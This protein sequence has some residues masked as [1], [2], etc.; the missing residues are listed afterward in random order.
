LTAAIF[1][2]TQLPQQRREDAGMTSFNILGALEI[3]CHGM[4]PLPSAP[5][6]RSLLALLL[7]RAGQLVPV[8]AI[9]DE[10]W[11]EA[12]PRS[13]VTTTQTYI[14]QLRKKLDETGANHGVT[15]LETAP[16]GYLLRLGDDDLDAVRF[17]RLSTMGTTL[18][19][20]GDTEG[21]GRV[22]R[23]ALALWRGPALTNVVLGP[24]LSAHVAHLD[25]LRIQALASRIEADMAQGRHRELVA[26]L[27]SLVCAYPLNEWFHGQLI[28]ALRRSGRRSDALVAYHH[29]RGLLQRELGLDPSAYLQR[30]HHAVLTADAPVREMAAHVPA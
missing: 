17:Y 20:R 19:E 8:D 3:E 14:C 26:E 7:V 9:I 4:V 12:P 18:A 29:V 2:F 27:R 15:M 24:L 30:L 13:A 10:L 5:K 25:E 21:A 28:E 16:P 6:V 1:R 22:F 23:D 11:G